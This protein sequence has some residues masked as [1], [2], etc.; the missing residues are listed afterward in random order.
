MMFR[1]FE[2]DGLNEGARS[3]R[4]GLPKPPTAH[5]SASP[6]NKKANFRTFGQT[7]MRLHVPSFR[8]S[9]ASSSFD[10]NSSFISFRYFD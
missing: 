7:L 5:D 8:G 10:P 2:F 1:H 6:L 3:C 4:V 9:A